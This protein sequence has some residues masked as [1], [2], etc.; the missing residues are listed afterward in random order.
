MKHRRVTKIATYPNVPCPILASF[1]YF[2]LALG[3]KGN[4]SSS[5]LTPCKLIVK[6]IHI[7]DFLLV[8][9][10]FHLLTRFT[11]FTSYMAFAATCILWSI[12]MLLCFI[13]IIVYLWG[14]TLEDNINVRKHSLYKFNYLILFYFLF[15]KSKT[16]L[17][18]FWLR[19]SRSLSQSRVISNIFYASELH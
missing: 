15:L 12:N 16:W 9:D 4:C 3:Q 19:L 17:H 1:S 10:G 14:L 2:S 18:I 5:F 13:F 7:N 6:K 8:T 11:C